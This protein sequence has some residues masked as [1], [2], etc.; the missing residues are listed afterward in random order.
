GSYDR[1]AIPMIT[2][3]PWASALPENEEYEE[4]REEKKVMKYIAQGVYDN[5]IREFI[6]ILKSY[7]KPVFLRFAHEFD[8]PQYPWSQVGEN[9][10]NEFIA[11]WKHVHDIASKENANKLVFVWN[12]WSIEGMTQYYPGNDFVD[13][14]GITL[15]NYDS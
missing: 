10:P 1:D 12:P 8:N 5:Y 9:S 14:I 3:E 15:L 2:W 6:Q 4:L 11:A 7:D 13:W